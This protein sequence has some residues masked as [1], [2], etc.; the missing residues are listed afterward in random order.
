MT[1]CDR[2]VKV[3]VVLHRHMSE[4]ITFHLTVELEVLADLHCVV[5]RT[6]VHYRGTQGYGGSPAF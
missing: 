1:Y 6:F 2:V 4:G 3:G 5:S